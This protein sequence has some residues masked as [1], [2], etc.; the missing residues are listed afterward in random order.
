MKLLLVK[1]R[2]GHWGWINVFILVLIVAAMSLPDLKKW[3]EGRFL[4]LLLPRISF[5][6]VLERIR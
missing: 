6:A 3:Y 1:G 2:A 5:L 4:K